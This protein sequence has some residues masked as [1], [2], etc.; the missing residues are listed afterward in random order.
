MKKLILLTLIFL[1][2]VFAFCACGNITTGTSTTTSKIPGITD[3]NHKHLY[4]STVV[5]PTCTEEG[6]TKYFCNCGDTYFDDYTAKKEHTVYVIHTEDPTCT[7]DGKKEYGC[8]NCDYKSTEYLEKLG[9]FPGDL[10]SISDP[11][12]TDYGYMFFICSVCGEEYSV[13]NTAPAGHTVST[14]KVTKEPTTE[15]FGEKEGY[16]SVCKSTVSDEIFPKY[17]ERLSY[18]LNADGTGYI[19]VGIGGCMNEFVNIPSEYNG[20]P[21]VAIGEAAFRNISWI[22]GVRIPNSITSIGDKAFYGCDDLDRI[23]IGTGVET[24]GEEAF[25]DCASLTKINITNYVRK[26]GNRAFG[27]CSSLDKM[28]IPESVNSIGEGAFYGCTSILSVG[29]IGS[30]ASLE[31]PL[32]K[33]MSMGIFEGCTSLAEVS[34]PNSVTKICASA[35]RGC[36]SLENLI[37]PDSVTEIEEGAFL[38]CSSL[39]SISISAKVE[40]LGASFGGCISLKNIEIDENNVYY[41]VINGSIYTKDQKTLVQY[42]QSNRSDSFHIPEGVITIGDLAFANSQFLRNVSISSS[43]VTIGSSA[44]MD[45]SSLER[46]Y[47]PNEE[48]SNLTTIETYAF[49]CS[50]IKEIQIPNS[51]SEIPGGTFWDCTAL[52]SVRL[53]ETIEY[54]PPFMFSGCTSLKQVNIPSNVKSISEEAFSFCTSLKTIDFPEGLILISDR[55]FWGCASLV[56][57]YIPKSVVNIYSDAFAECPKLTIYCE[58]ETQPS[59]YWS[60]WCDSTT[61]VIWGYNRKK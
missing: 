27:N 43:V 29:P 9:H 61:T 24:I 47:F 4:N 46:V 12:C 49:M 56:E 16:C 10:V 17:S 42:S 6:Y 54:I 32:V 48:E 44:F 5:K 3:P 21:V 22:V 20:K 35:F 51:V 11:S 53:P 8:V 26:I 52:E 40:H 59:G 2:T 13:P 23:T 60:G 18:K 33:E 55:A 58:Y 38:N 1:I 36:K 34:I 37:I 14:W 45:C 15:H 50:G 25:F 31:I 19:L 57:A 28:I 7:K 39:K 41:T 30:G